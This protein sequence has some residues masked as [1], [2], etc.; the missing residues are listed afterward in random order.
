V[1]FI[2]GQTGEPLGGIVFSNA[3]AQPCTLQGWPYVQAR[4]L[5]NKRWG[6]GDWEYRNLPSGRN[7]S[8]PPIRAVVLRPRGKSE[9]GIH[10]AWRNWCAGTPL[11][12]VLHFGNT[13]GPAITLSVPAGVDAAAAGPCTDRHDPEVSTLYASIVHRYDSTIGFHDT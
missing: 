11:A 5:V 6:G 1:R 7:V 9:A 13:H 10:L 4:G 3:S 8:L 12:L 2:P